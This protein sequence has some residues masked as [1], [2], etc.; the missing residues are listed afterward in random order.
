MLFVSDLDG[1][2]LDHTHEIDDTVLKG[3]KEVLAKGHYFVICTGR[4]M[5]AKGAINFG[6]KH[7]HI[8][9]I[10]MNGALTYDG[11]ASLIA[12]RPIDKEIIKAFYYDLDELFV[13]YETS[14]YALHPF[15]YERVDAY[16]YEENLF[17]EQHHQRMSFYNQNSRFQVKLDELLSSDIYKINIILSNTKL[18]EKADAALIK[19]SDK[20]VNAPWGEGFYDIT[21]IKV[22]KGAAVKALTNKLGISDSDVYV[23]GDSYNDVQMLEMFSNSTSPSNANS[24]AKAVA[25]RIIGDY[26]EH[27][28]IKDILAK[29]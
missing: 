14:E 23:Y 25:K 12:N 29:I 11:S 7:E 24:A 9:T 4:G 2:L 16:L 18:K 15:T 1:T 27:S 6:I 5:H 21:D 26:D 17:N 10:A 8:Y 3:I 19:Y 13:R 22:N 28:V 20:V